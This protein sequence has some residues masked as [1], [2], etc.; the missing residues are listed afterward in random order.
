MAITGKTPA[1]FI[2]VMRLKRAAQLMENSQ[3]SVSE[4]SYEVGFNGSRYFSNHFKDFFKISPSEYIKLQRLK[5]RHS[6][7]IITKGR[8]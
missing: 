2:K 7:G 4:I 5:N 6:N 1:E 8:Q 3:M